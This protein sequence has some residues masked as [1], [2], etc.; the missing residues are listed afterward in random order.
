[1]S[2]PLRVIVADDEPDVCLLLKLQLADAGHDVVAEAINGAEV[3]TACE[4]THP[5]VI[6][7]DLLMPVMT[8]FEAIPLLQRDHPDVGI[9]AYTAVAGDFVREEMSRYGIRL[10]LKSGQPHALLEALAETAR[11]SPIS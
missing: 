11:K 6:V 2:G 7:L 8:G 10:V 4:L 5:D 1:M 9:V 3:L